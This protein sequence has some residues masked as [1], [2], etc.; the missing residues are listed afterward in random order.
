M[1]I[2]QQRL[3]MLVGG[4]VQ[5][6]GFRP[7]VYRCA[8]AHGLTGHVENTAAGVEIQVQGPAEAIQAFQ[9]DFQHQLPPLARLTSCIEQPLPPVAQEAAFSIHH[10]GA[11]GGGHTVLVS[12]DVA[13]CPDC[14]ADIL[15]PRNRRHAY[16]F[17]N[18]TNCGPRYSITHTIPYD[19]ATTSM[20]CFP[21]CP[22]C[23]AEYANPLDRRFH[24]QPNACP[25]CGP[26]VWV[27]DG[28][29]AQQG[30]ESPWATTQDSSAIGQDP[31]A[32]SFP[33]ALSS[34]GMPQALTLIAQALHAGRIA[35]IKGLGGFQLAC[36]ALDP[37]AI[38]LLRSRKHRPH[39]ALALMVPDLAT[40]R[41]L[42]ECSPEQEAQLSS[43]EAPIV[44]CRQRTQCTAL[45]ASIAPD[46]HNIGLMLP[47]TPLHHLLLQAYA[48][49]AGTQPVALIM[50]SGNAGGEPI[51]LGNR[52]ALDRL[53]GMADIF[54]LHNRD[55]LVRVDDSVLAYG[56]GNAVP[57]MYRRAR[58]YVPRP[59]ALGTAGPCIMGMGAEL[60]AT[61]CLTRGDAAFV[62]Q[63]IGDVHNVETFG[64]YQE[65]AR[66]LEILLEVRPEALVCDLHPDYMTSHYAQNLQ[67]ERGTAL[68]CLQHHAAHGWS[69]LTEHGH[70]GPAL[71]WALD[72]T[73]LGSSSGE[74][75][76]VIGTGLGASTIEEHPVIGA[77]RSTVSSLAKNSTIGAAPH[78]IESDPALGGPW[79]APSH[80]T[81]SPA[82]WGGELLYIDTHKVCQRRVGRLVPF[83]LPGG[84]AAAREPWRVAQSLLT[85][86]DLPWIWPAPHNEHA[87]FISAMVRKGV[88]CP[89][90]SSMGRLFD[91]VSALLGLCL[92]TTYEGQAALRLQEAQNG[93]PD[94]LCPYT[95]PIIAPSA[96]PTSD[97]GG[98][99][100]SHA[101]SAT[102]TYDPYGAD[103]DK[104]DPRA[105]PSL[106]Q[107][108]SHSLFASI[109]ADLLGGVPVSHIARKFHLTLAQGLAQMAGQ[110]ARY[111]A[112]Q[113]VGLT[114]GVMQNP[115][116]VHLLPKALAE[117][118]LH[119]LLHRDLPPN[120]GSI[121][122]GQA[123]FGR[124][125]LAR[126][127][128]TP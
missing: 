53:Q 40:A 89:P 117:H 29:S 128:A 127:E 5:G 31:A 72:G 113:H 109:H 36:N 35:A 69:V 120:D 55:I 78:S 32:P 124:A 65:V 11:G 80:S 115:S 112:V 82:L 37:A 81:H 125:M 79:H 118:G 63:H 54:L 67:Q 18:C 75:H 106:W 66:H 62:S 86:L 123:A 101:L 42:A 6:V 91:A 119:A 83:P 76:P 45:P 99:T 28:K 77:G 56:E 98:S 126:H 9:H 85:L 71:V 15:S 13:L 17:T 94:D 68:F 103:S 33:S 61:L 100:G 12:P 104:A 52:E 2:Q 27:V 21:Q 48:A 51:C 38:A 50:T 24:A 22:A 1:T 46:G 92:V 74:E 60:K 10:S 3:Q 19:R 116:L 107:W 7:F 20:A 105:H 34:S 39:K 64:F 96:V 121:A 43:A 14:L 49:L 30:Q 73:G 93:A 58:G 47:Y 108:D 84:D 25:V 114:G 8:V 16:P 122:L 88:Q 26:H 4:Q 59:I 44:I 110:V 95:V 57:I 41:L 23:E 70:C 102:D 111:Y 97:M 90:C 87:P